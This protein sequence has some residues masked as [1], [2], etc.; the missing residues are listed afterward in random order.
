M[1]RTPSTRTAAPGP[2]PLVPEVASALSPLVRRI[3]CN[4]P[5]LMTGPGTNTYLVGVDEIVVVDPGPDDATHL[6]AIAGCGG[7]AIRWIVCTH[8][9]PDHS[10]GA[11]GLKARTGAEVLAF[12]SRDDLV[13]DRALG[14]RRRH[15]GNRVP[16]QRHPHTRPR[17]EPPL[18]PLGRGAAA[19]SRA[20]TS[21]A[22]R[23]WSSARRT[24][25]WSRISRRSNGFGA[26]RP[27]LRS[28]A[29]AHGH[30]IDR[31]A[32]KIDEYLSHRRAREAQ[33]MDALRSAGSP[34]YRHRGAGGRHL[35]RCRGAPPPGGPPLGLGALAQASCRGRRDLLGSRRSR[36]HVGRR[37]K[38]CFE[39]AA[40]IRGAGHRANFKGTGHMADYQLFINGEYRD[41]ASGE[42]F[43]TTDPATGEKIA[44]VAK[45]GKEDAIAAP[46]P[47]PARR[48]TRV[49]GR[50]L[51]G[52]E[53]AAKLNK[54]AELHRRQGREVRRDGGPRR[55]R[56][57]QEGHVRRRPR[58]AGRVPVV[59][60]HGRGAAR[61]RSTCRARR[62]R[63]RRTTSS[64]S[65]TACA[66]ASSRG[67]SP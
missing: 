32:A 36:C 13:I 17:I 60:P 7:D 59:R 54:I 48:S 52:K 53:R 44:D 16:P 38:R 5:G 14:R 22:S 28:I 25:T 21:W 56:H 61:D 30:L 6:D 33:V 20:T 43:A 47:R 18:L 31:P 9:H 49:R 3:V 1:R 67:T 62:S 45:A 65:R 46:S 63:R 50:A 37:L 42:T 11:A 55:R 8:T 26:L 34:R 29:P 35:H 57:D 64:T 2:K 15:R 12:D 40:T 66:P 4:N 10:P 39:A 58:R 23:R 41:A 19:A 24:A 27:P 51:S